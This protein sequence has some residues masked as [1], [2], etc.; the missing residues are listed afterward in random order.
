MMHAV[1]SLKDSM[2]A[3]KE[4]L[5]S[6]EVRKTM[7]RYRG[8]GKK[9]LTNR[10]ISYCLIVIFDFCVILILSTRGR[11][12]VMYISKTDNHDYRI[13]ISASFCQERKMHSKDLKI[14]LF[15][16]IQSCNYQQCISINRMRKRQVC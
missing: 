9:V 10:E 4:I 15:T 6:F 8:R 14:D 12:L 11:N 2:Q 5:F 16:Y 7:D 1:V 3:V 13:N